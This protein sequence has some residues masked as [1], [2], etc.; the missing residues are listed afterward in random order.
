MKVLYYTNI[1]APYRVKFFNQL[2]KHVDLMEIDQNLIVIK[3]GL[4]IIT[5]NLS[6]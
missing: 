6:L 3:N 4:K 1:P 5:L 2:S